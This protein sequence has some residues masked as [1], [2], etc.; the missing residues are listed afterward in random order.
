MLDQMIKGKSSS[1]NIEFPELFLKWER[2]YFEFYNAVQLES[3]SFLYRFRIKCIACYEFQL[4]FA[5][6]GWSLL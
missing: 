3:Y 5:M 1:G 6:T 4:I 2:K